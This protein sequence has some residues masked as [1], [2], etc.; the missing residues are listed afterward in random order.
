MASER[1]LRRNGLL[2]DPCRYILP[3]Q[4]F[5]DFLIGLPMV[6]LEGEVIFREEIALVKAFGEQCYEVEARFGNDPGEPTWMFYLEPD[7]YRLQS[8]RFQ[9]SSGGGEWIYYP[10][11]AAFGQMRL[12]QLQLWYHFDGEGLISRDS[13]NYSEVPR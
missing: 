11:D 1:D 8:A 5:F 7:T 4:R 10:R 12:K 3:R 9:N 2:E 13:L 6:A